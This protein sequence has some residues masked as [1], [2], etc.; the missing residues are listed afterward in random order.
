M[1]AYYTKEY[2]SQ[3]KLDLLTETY[4][5]KILSEDTDGCV[6]AKEVQLYDKDDNIRKIYSNEVIL[7][8][9]ALQSPQVL[10]NSSIGSKEILE[11]Y[12]IEH[13]IDNPGVG[14]NFQDHCFMTVSFKVAD[15]HIS[16]EVVRDPAV[17]EALLKQYQE[18][19]TGPLSGIPFSLAYVPPVDISGR[20]GREDVASP[21]KAHLGV[22]ESSLDP[23]GKA[24][25]AQLQSM[26]LD[27]KESTCFYGLMASQM[28]I[29]REGKTSMGQAYSQQL[30]QNSITIMFGLNHPL[31][32]GSIHLRSTDQDANP[33]LILATCRTQWTLKSWLEAPSSSRGLWINQQ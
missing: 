18:T 20:M 29:R 9:G 17:V 26:M 15:G 8:D 16:G 5:S 12:G 4:M 23:S 28:H 1:S 32:H 27:P 33:L 30:P 10:E 13:V 3:P 22:N 31:S 21:M 11:R 7:A 6:T 19:R 2:D 25:F 14:E 24:Q